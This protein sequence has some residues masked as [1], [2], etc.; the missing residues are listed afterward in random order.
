MKKI[1]I[2]AAIILLLFLFVSC[3]HPDP[4][5]YELVSLYN[6]SEIK[7][8]FFLG[9]GWIGEEEY[10]FSFIKTSLGIKRHKVWI[11]YCYIIEDENNN[12]HIIKDSRPTGSYRWYYHVPKETIIRKMELK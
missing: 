11:G 7:G 2:I 12:P 9:S 3:G 8:S 10:I 1:I 6:D 4:K 5:R